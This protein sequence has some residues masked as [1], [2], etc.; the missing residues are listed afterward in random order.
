MM[1]LE[2]MLASLEGY[3]FDPSLKPL[4]LDT[5]NAEVAA[6]RRQANVIQRRRS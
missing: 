1:N 5:R 6:L 3:S 2:V 4:Q